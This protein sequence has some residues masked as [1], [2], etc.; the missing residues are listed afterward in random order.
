MIGT[1]LVPS[2]RVAGH[3]VV[4]LV[5]STPGASDVR[6][7]PSTGTIDRKRLAGIEGA[8]HL[9]GEN[10]GT[11]WNE[12]KKRRIMDSR[13]NGTRLLAEA[14]ATL[15]PRPR[16]MVSM[17]GVGYYGA[18]RDDPLTDESSAG[19]GFLAD[20]CRAWEASTQPA[21]DAGTRVAI[22]RMGV[23][24][25]RRG[26]ALANLVTPFKLGL[27]GPI[28][29]GWRW[30]SWVS[31]HDA[32][33]AIEHALTDESWRGPRIVATPNPVTNRDF[34]KTLGNVLGRPAFLP[35]PAAPLR[36]VFGEMADEAL[37]ASQRCEPERL[38]ASGFSF[39]HPELGG[40]LRRELDKDAS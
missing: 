10:V 5:R 28:A 27:G 7:D 36:L 24:L 34:S 18:V 20:V 21:A 33:R 39:E 14:L 16:V 37:L 30:L 6:W 1:A 3:D 17:S 19:T 9:A 35:L 8:V 13:K 32:V 15:E 40:A 22:L 4:R 25:S 11:R 31:L 12:A 2:L 23:V 38:L 26:G 29:G